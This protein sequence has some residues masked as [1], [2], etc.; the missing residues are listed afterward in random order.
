[1]Q[2]KT[3][4]KPESE[5]IAATVGHPPDSPSG[6]YDR[7]KYVAEVMQTLKEQ[8]LFPQGACLVQR[9]ADRT[10]HFDELSE[11]IVVGRSEDAAIS[12]DDSRLSRRHFSLCH[13]DDSWRIE[14][15]GSTNGTRVN[16][17]SLHHTRALCSGD[18]IEAGSTVFVYLE[19]FEHDI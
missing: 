3:D 13:R 9:R 16:G 17:E 7:L 6:L 5:A 18:L 14:D 4:W 12:L 19:A 15:L 1:M 10:V 11:D 2:K 8:D